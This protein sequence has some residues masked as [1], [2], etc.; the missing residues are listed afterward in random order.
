MV[1]K[2][3][4]S[5]L[6]G[7]FNN[8]GLVAIAGIGIA[9]FIFRK[10]IQEAFANFGTSIGN[11]GNITLPEIKLPEIKL[12]DITLPG[13]PTLP[14]ITFPPIFG[15]NPILPNPPPEF[16]P[17]VIPT[18]EEIVAPGDISNCECGGVLQNQFGV[19]FVVCNQ[20]TGPFQGPIQPPLI[21]GNI[22]DT[23]GNLPPQDGID[24]GPES[25]FGGGP[26]FEGGKTTF[27]DNLIDSLSE[28]L[29]IFGN[30]TASQASNL[31][32]DNPGLS[33]NEFAQID[34]FGSSSISS[35]GIDPDQ[36]FNNSSGDFSGL[37]P[38]QIANILTGGNINNF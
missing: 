34:P 25:P 9:L 10:P 21:P 31:L 33:G 38:E 28:V 24:V 17:P 12:P 30:L 29:N 6:G 8:P 18:D 35:E 16:F 19:N 2:S 5:F 37:T 4:G 13:L 14:D 26:S 20:C 11:L 23:F 3:A 32:A 15:S 36:I 27:G 1:A 7:F 22:E